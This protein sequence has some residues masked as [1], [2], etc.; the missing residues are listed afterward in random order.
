MAVRNHQ[1]A[2]ALPW[3]ALGL[4]LA[5]IGF[6]IVPLLALGLGR[7]ASGL[8]AYAAHVLLFTLW[9]AF[10]SATVS[11]AF[12][13]LLARALA[14]R[15][16]P[17]RGLFIR[18]LIIPQALP[19][20]VVVL[21]LLGIFGESGWMGGIIPAYG[22]AGI[23]LAHVFF[24]MPLVTRLLLARLDAL[25]P[26]SA[27]LAEQLRFSDWQT[28]RH[29]EWPV[30]E[31]AVKGGFGLVFLLCAASFTVVLVLGGGPQATT[32]EVA[33]YQALRMDF[34]PGFAALLGVAQLLVCSVAILVAG[35]M[36]AA[37]DILP[38]TLAAAPKK[39]AGLTALMLDSTIILAA[40]ALV[41]P[42][43]LVLATAGIM[44]ISLSA[45]LGAA[46]FNSLLLGV[47]ATTLSLVFGWLL[48]AASERQQHPLLRA[49]FT[50]AAMASLIMPPAV[51]ATG[52]F[53]SLAPHTDVASLAPQLIVLLNALMA[54]P[55]V[56]TILQPAIADSFARH[57]RLCQSLDLAGWQRLRFVEFRALR[58]PLGLAATAALLLSL[59]DLAAVTL[60]G[61][62][63][64]VTLPA[65]VYQ[66]MGH[67]QM[68]E[69]E[70]T[71][72]VLAL[73]T[74]AITF[75]LAPRLATR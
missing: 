27:R 15:R 58:Q 20:I 59:G 57:D 45:S 70:G 56:R 74:L 50:L 30:L 72:L 38:R 29:V 64:W 31:P 12:G 75:L 35:K 47:C 24:N 10:L 63:E 3:L 39:R 6:G 66:Q 23:L 68:A 8:T 55:F 25:P 17:G 42:P 65:L 69:A 62:D 16:F 14:A 71:A 37:P 36:A 54:L 73:L 48:A 28:F 21:A 5:L 33:I 61:T 51:L 19:A 49:L 53:V 18:L 60:F 46:L 44:H 41:L 43:L 52:W 26:E 32:L 22:L 2:V 4:V 9:Q 67:Y 1:I 13:L 34:D 11:V 7:G 40:L